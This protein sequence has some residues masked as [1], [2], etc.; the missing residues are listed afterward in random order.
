MLSIVK[1]LTYHQIIQIIA[2]LINREIYL[3]KY[4]PKTLDNES[5]QLK[6]KEYFTK[7]LGK[8][9]DKIDINL[10]F[11]FQ[12]KDL[13]LTDRINSLI[14][15]HTQTFIDLIKNKDKLPQTKYIPLKLVYFNINLY[16]DKLDYENLS[17]QLQKVTDPDYYFIL[18]NFYIP[19]TEENIIVY[20]TFNNTTKINI[21]PKVNCLI[22]K[23]DDKYKINIESSIILKIPKNFIINIDNKRFENEILKLSEDLCK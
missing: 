17:L 5:I 18:D 12:L 14:S 19:L 16:L 3:T 1:K 21:E 23:Q 8:E 11:N 6:F 10:N 2:E 22:D 9:F 7:I 15:V 13:S 20:S 4:L